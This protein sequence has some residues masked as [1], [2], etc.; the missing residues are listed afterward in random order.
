VIG[1]KEVSAEKFSIRDRKSGSVKELSIDDLI[2][3]I[4][5]Q[6][7]NKPFMKLNMNRELSKRPQIMV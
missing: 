4:K 1:E 3:E 7:R 2:K 6:T 5:E